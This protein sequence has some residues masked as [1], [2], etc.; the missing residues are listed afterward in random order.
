MPSVGRK[1]L[2][3]GV[4]GLNLTHG[5]PFDAFVARYG[6]GAPVLAPLLRDFGAD[7][8]ARVGG[9]AGHRHLRRQFGPRLSHRHEGRAP[10]A[11]LAAPAARAGRAAAH[12]AP[13]AGLGRRRRVAFRHAAGRVGRGA[14]G[15]RAGARRRQL[16][17]AGLRRRLVALAAGARRRPGAAAAV[18]LRFRRRLERTLQ[19]PPCRRAA[20]VGGHQRSTAG[21]RWA[22]ASSP[23]AAS[24]AASSMPRRRALR[25]RIARDGAATFELDLLPQRSL[26]VGDAR[27]GPPARAALAVHAPEDAAAACRA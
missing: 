25:E 26:D 5:E 17:A 27:T 23:P 18:Q 4:G 7:A 24:R 15:H 21:A 13:L 20:E 8:A 2:L 14:A 12:A 22:N 16:A 10:A 11:R 1:F 6:R 3:A 19:P 9:G